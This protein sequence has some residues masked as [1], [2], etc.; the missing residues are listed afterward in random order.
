MVGLDFVPKATHAFD[1]SIFHCCGAITLSDGESFMSATT[2][3]QNTVGSNPFAS[4]HSYSVAAVELM[5]ALRTQR[6]NNGQ[7]ESSPDEILAV[8]E[9]LGY[10]NKNAAQL[11]RPQQAKRFVMALEREKTRRQSE[12]VSCDDVL[13]VIQSL[14]YRRSNPVAAMEVTRGLP[15]DRRRREADERNSK[16]ERRDDPTPGLQETLELTEDENAFLDHLK[17]LREQYGREFA[18]SQELLS[19]LWSLNYRPRQN[20]GQFAEDLTEDQ[21]FAIQIAF[22][23]AIEER[24][25]NDCDDE[26]VTARSVLQV[27]DELGFHK[28]PS[29]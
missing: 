19:I 10:R 14:G 11:N 12:Y 2:S 5:R 29:A 1:Q 17:A 3:A 26:F 6:V 8:L 20:N 9:R 15:I 21:R 7:Q 23:R 22:T 18:S 25:S 28:I 24:I 27:V 13:E 16:T 4:E